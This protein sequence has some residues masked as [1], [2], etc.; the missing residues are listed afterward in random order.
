[1]KPTRYN[2]HYPLILIISSFLCFN[3]TSCTPAFIATAIAGASI[4]YDKRTTGT[5]IDD[6]SIELK[7]SSRI[8]G[9]SFYNSSNLN[10]TSYNLNLLIVGQVPSAKAKQIILTKLKTIPRVRKIYNELEIK[11][12]LGIKQQAK[13]AWIT[14]KIKTFLKTSKKTKKLQVKVVTENSSVY[15]LGI[16]SP[17]QANDITNVVRNISGVNKITRLFEYS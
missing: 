5:I 13:D 3:L 16:V 10:I 7:A 4:A 2:K 8:S 6:E 11:K 17:K 15:L 12:P 14:G 1:M 9:E